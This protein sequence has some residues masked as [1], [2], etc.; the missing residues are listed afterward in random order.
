ME[1]CFCC[2]SSSDSTQGLVWCT[3]QFV[4]NI[5]SKNSVSHDHVKTVSDLCF[6]VENLNY[7]FTIFLE[8]FMITTIYFTKHIPT[9]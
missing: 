2:F 8:I 7:K 5:I 4:Q 9:L 6:L 3:R 1:K